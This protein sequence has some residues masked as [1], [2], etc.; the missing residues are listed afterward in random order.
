MAFVTIEIELVREN[1]VEA[2]CIECFRTSA[3]VTFPF[4]HQPFT[5]PSL[6]LRVD[7]ASSGPSRNCPLNAE[8]DSIFDSSGSHVLF[9]RRSKPIFCYPVRALQL[10]TMTI[11]NTVPVALYCD[12]RSITVVCQQRQTI[13]ALDRML[14]NHRFP[15]T[16]IRSFCQRNTVDC[17][18]FCCYLMLSNRFACKSMFQRSNY[19]SSYPNRNQS[20]DKRKWFGQFFDSINAPQFSVSS[21]STIVATLYPLKESNVQV[22]RTTTFT[23]FLMRSQPNS[24][25]LN[26]SKVTSKSPQSHIW[27]DTVKRLIPTNKHRLQAK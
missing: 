2:H 22:K 13:A 9:T 11:P 27:T 20:N 18:L 16:N 7:L 19:Q 25:S 17:C 26:T 3:R 8:L 4:H 6:A 1:K 10:V 21:N 23:A 12:F 14:D 5:R 15:C 24:N